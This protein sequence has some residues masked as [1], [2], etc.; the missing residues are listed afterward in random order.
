MDGGSCC[1]PLPGPKKLS[2]LSNR[3]LQLWP[4]V[5]P[6]HAASPGRV[7]PNFSERLSPL[8]ASPR[9]YLLL[10]IPWYKAS[11]FRPVPS[12]DS[13]SQWGWNLATTASPAISHGPFDTGRNSAP[14][15]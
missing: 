10:R 2:N 9:E 11:A 7:H 1:N 15:L 12:G 3:A 8:F 5:W 6:L 4:F 14:H 13:Q